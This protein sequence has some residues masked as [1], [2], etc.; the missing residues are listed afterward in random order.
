MVEVYRVE[1]ISDTKGRDKRPGLDALPIDAS[2]RRFDVAMCWA[3]DRLGRSLID[4]LGTIQ[5]L[6]T[7]GVDLYLDQQNIDTTTPMGRLL[8]QI[9][10]AFAEFGRSMIR[11]RI[12]SGLARDSAAIKRDGKFVTR[13][14]IV[15]SRLGRPWF[16]VDLEK[17]LCAELAKG[18]GIV[19]TAKRIGVGNSTV[20]KIAR[21]I[22]A[23]EAS[24]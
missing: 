6:E 20:H 17:R 9:T 4:L 10:G 2:R 7:A 21:K 1:G 11:E 14:G 23:A 22:R 15:R 24:T 16:S 5:H 19:K 3:I 13:A 12:K 8:F 18:T